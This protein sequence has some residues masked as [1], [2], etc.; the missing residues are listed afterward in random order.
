MSAQDPAQ[1]EHDR[2]AEPDDLLAGQIGKAHGDPETQA[3]ADHGTSRGVCPK[4]IAD[5]K[6][7]REQQG[8]QQH[9]HGEGLM[10]SGTTDEITKGLRMAAIRPDASATEPARRRSSPCTRPASL[11][12]PQTRARQGHP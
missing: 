9:E 7:P 3:G 2:Q 5:A 11:A 12:N 8:R 1:H 4:T 10:E 6:D